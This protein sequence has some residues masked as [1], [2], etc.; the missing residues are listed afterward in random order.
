MYYGIG[1]GGGIGVGLGGG[2]FGMIWVV[3]V[4][5]LLKCRCVLCFWWL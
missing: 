1:L 3:G 5:F 4:V 2:L